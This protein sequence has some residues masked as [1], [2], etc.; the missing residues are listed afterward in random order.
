MSDSIYILE[1][2]IANDLQDYVRR[3]ICGVYSTLEKAMEA[4]DKLF[5]EWSIDADDPF[6]DEIISAYIYCKKT[7]ETDPF[8][9]PI[10]KWLSG[11]KRWMEA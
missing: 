11:S 8:A 7:D 9:M 2:S 3:N 1:I 10:Y 6:C 4:G 5:K